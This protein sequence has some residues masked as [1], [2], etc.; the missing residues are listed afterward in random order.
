M[1]T[2][3]NS[4]LSLGLLPEPLQGLLGLAVVLVFCYFVVSGFSIALNEI[5][6]RLQ[7][8]LQTRY[9]GS[10]FVNVFSGGLLVLLLLLLP[11]LGW[12]VQGVIGVTGL[13]AAV[14]MLFQRRREQA[15]SG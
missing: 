6:E 5:G 12:L 3:I 10:T 7:N 14:S 2:L 1:H 15:P 11:F 13:G 8:N 4:S 9:V